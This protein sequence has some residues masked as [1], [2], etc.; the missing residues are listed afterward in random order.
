MPK[1]DK[2]Q[3][4]LLS[5]AKVLAAYAAVKVKLKKLYQM[6]ELDIRDR[7]KLRLLYDDLD[8]MSHQYMPEHIN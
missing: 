1:L 5:D 2:Q 6:D 4:R 8:I 7:D 3:R